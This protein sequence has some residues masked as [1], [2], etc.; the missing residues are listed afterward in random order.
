VLQVDGK[1]PKSLFDFGDLLASGASQAVRLSVQRADKIINFTVDLVPETSVFN[2]AMVRDRLGLTLEKKAG[3]FLVT[4]VQP[5]STAAASGLREGMLIREVDGQLPPPD[6]TSLARL[7]YGKKS[8]EPLLLKIA[9]VERV[10]NFDVLHTGNV[11]VAL[12]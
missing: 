1:A 11:R 7:L 8:G 6:I 3:G 2:A 4:K 12:R 9:L 10:G 5:S